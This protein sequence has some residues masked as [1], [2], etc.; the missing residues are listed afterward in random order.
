MRTTDWLLLVL[1][2]VLWGGSFFFAAVAVRDIPPLT[3]VLARVAL[4]AALL[5]PLARLLGLS[6]PRSLAAWRPYVVL[7]LLNNLVPFSLIVY[8]QTHIASGL[9]SVLNATTP[10]FTLMVARI[11][12]GEPLTAARLG[13]VAAGHGRRGRADGPRRA[14]RR[15]GRRARHAVRAGRGAVLWPLRAVDAPPEGHPAAGLG[16]RRSSCA[17]RSMLLPV[18]GLVDRFW[19]LPMPGATA[20]RRRARAGG[21]LHGARLHRL[22]PHQRHR[23][24]RATSCW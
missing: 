3:L 15:R 1:L 13:G 22:L 20:D 8:G 6:L 11:F 23:P 10:L 17:R 5:A 14:Q 7:A 16:R 21:L 9:A 12:A 18:A 19:A 4:A 2:S 24:A